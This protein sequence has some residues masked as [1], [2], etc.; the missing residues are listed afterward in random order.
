MLLLALFSLVLVG[1]N[2]PEKEPTKAELYPD[3]IYVGEQNYYVMNKSGKS[4]YS[5]HNN[6]KE[7]HQKFPTYFIEKA[8][9]WPREDLN[10]ASSY[11]LPRF[12]FVFSNYSEGADES[13]SRYK[14]WSMKTDGTDLRL[15][16]DATI[17]VGK[18]DNLTRSPN[19][20]YVA[21]SGKG[22]T[23]YDLKTGQITQLTTRVGPSDM[24]WSED[25][26][27][28]YI[29]ISRST[30][31][32]WDAKTG[33]LN[34]TDLKIRTESVFN[35]DKLIVVADTGVVGYNAKTNERLF[36]LGTDL[37]IGGQNRGFV[38]KAISPTGRFAWGFAQRTSWL[39]DTKNKTSKKVAE[40]GAAE[41]LGKDA[42]YSSVFY[43]GG[44]SGTS[45]VRIFDHVKNQFWAWAPF[46]R[47]S[48]SGDAILY[49]GLANDGLWFKAGEHE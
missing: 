24:L 39:F 29:E 36:I 38:R 44:R 37:K 15:V 1:C 32:R 43:Y 25:S 40:Y 12:Q 46:T 14:I 19:H 13:E 5:I 2:E 28:L 48:M 6:A 8:Q 49:N 26:R 3:R 45:N 30:Y 11:D 42:H 18:V 17:P 27:Y 47:G 16:M 7:M 41:I 35:G 21:W 34:K 22:K 10:D 20:R 23:V 4:P 31:M 33:D 9:E